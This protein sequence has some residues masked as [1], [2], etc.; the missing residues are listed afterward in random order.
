MPAPTP[1]PPPAAKTAKAIPTPPPPAPT[2]APEPKVTMQ[3][4]AP[5][6][7]PPAPRKQVVVTPEPAPEKPQQQA[8]LQPPTAP[9][10]PLEPGVLVSVPF[11]AGSEN[12]S[13]TGAGKLDTLATKMAQTG[14]R[15][16]LKAYASANGSSESA[17]RR[18]SLSR[19]LKVRSHLIRNGVAS[20][21][22]D[23]RALGVAQDGPPD[24][25]DVLVLQR[26]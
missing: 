17:A 14:T 19:A 6:V 5:P 8:S 24:R 15:L 22:I 16:Q 25:V 23:V 2:P 12:L 26:K 10:T 21:R 4:A 3:K 13:D 1:P 18:L 9:I 7:P 20:T 11:A